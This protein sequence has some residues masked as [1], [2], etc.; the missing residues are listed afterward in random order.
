ML[1]LK[2]FVLKILAHQEYFAQKNLVSIKNHVQRQLW[3]QKIFCIWKTFYTSFNP[4]PDKR[5]TPT[6]HLPNNLQT[7]SRRFVNTTRTSLKI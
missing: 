2:T 5:Q 6:K 3:C 4:L 7:P 1:C